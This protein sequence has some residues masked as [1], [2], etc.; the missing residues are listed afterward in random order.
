MNSQG[1][2]VHLAGRMTD[3]VF[4][5]LGPATAA[6]AATG[7][8]QVVVMIDAPQFRHLLSQFDARVE[9]VP[10]PDD[11]LAPRRWRRLA[12]AFGSTVE[13]DDLRAVHLHGF[14]PWLVCAFSA[15]AR[16]DVP[17]YYSPHGSKSLDAARL[18]TRPAL[19]ATRA[20]FVPLVER[21]IASIA[22]EASTLQALLGHP[23]AVLEPPVDRR[24][25]AQRRREAPAPLIVTS[26]RIEDPRSAE[27]VLQM[28]VLLGGEELRLSFNWIGPVDAVSAVRLKAAGVGVAGV[29]G[30]AERA[31][32]LAAGWVYVAHGRS[33]GFPLHVAEAMAAGLP[34]VAIDSPMHRSVLSHGQ[35][36]MLCSDGEDMLRH[37]ARLVD[38]GE[39][40]RRL[41]RAARREAEQRFAASRFRE[42]VLAAYEVEHR[43]PA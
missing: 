18:F 32:R 12:R 30:I 29:T 14:V 22:A 40:R 35:T 19:W 43:L 20:A 13:R 7:V 41:G 33:R 16:R 1:V 39:L 25:F 4:G 8:K 3:L 11:R 42:Q 23:V 9:I 10:L 15:G 6:L 17:L 38:D 27:Q 34:C 2:V 37:V 5:F 28:A 21:S 24:F 26:G 31:A 36:G